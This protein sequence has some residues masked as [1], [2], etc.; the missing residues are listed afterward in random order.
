MVT[1]GNA[2]K[3]RV[4]PMGVKPLISCKDYFELYYFFCLGLIELFLRIKSVTFAVIKVWYY[5][6]KYD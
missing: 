2:E 3:M 5:L 1:T 4:F 6:L